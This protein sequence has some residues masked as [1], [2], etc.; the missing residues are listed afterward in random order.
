MFH[1]IVA[2]FEGMAVLNKK[3]FTI[4]EIILVVALLGVLS[5][6][7]IPIYK[8]TMAY[9]ELH[10]AAR[11]ISTDIRLAQQRAITEGKNYLV[12]F[13]TVNNKYLIKSNSSDAELRQ[14]PERIAIDYTS[15]ADNTLTFSPSGAPT[16]GHVGISDVYG[17]NLYIIVAVATGRVRISNEPPL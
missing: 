16:A 15:F 7:S 1:G 2:C 17:N 13:D 6:I 8:K 10:T 4:V 5:T 12:L 11:M 14:L 9:Y 3:G